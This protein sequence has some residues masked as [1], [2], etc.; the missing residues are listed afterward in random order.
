M[1]EITTDL[2][3]ADDRLQLC[4]LCHETTNWQ[5]LSQRHGLRSDVHLQHWIL[6][7]LLP[8]V[9]IIPLAVFVLVKILLLLRRGV[10]KAFR[11]RHSGTAINAPEYR[12]SNSQ[13]A[14]DGQ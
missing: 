10:R 8:L 11:L 7:T 5:P 14:K 13:V 3:G 12:N 1:P 2:T 9:F 6:A 4:C